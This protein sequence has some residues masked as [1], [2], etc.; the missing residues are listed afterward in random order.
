MSPSD[1]ADTAKLEEEV[2]HDGAEKEEDGVTKDQE[3]ESSSREDPSGK[4]LYLPVCY[5]KVNLE[6]ACAYAFDIDYL[7]IKHIVLHLKAKII[8]KLLLDT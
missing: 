8:L 3:E 6:H 4:H 5:G 1:D 2:D 7:L